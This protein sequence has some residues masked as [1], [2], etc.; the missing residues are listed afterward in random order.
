MKAA[1]WMLL[2]VLVSS[3]A[4]AV[5]SRTDFTHFTIFNG[6][7][8]TI[9]WTDYG[10][11]PNN[12]F[13]WGESCANVLN[14]AA[15]GIV[16]Q[17]ITQSPG[18]Q[19]QSQ[20]VIQHYPDSVNSTTP[21]SISYWF[22]S[23]SG[24][25][26]TDGVF[27]LHGGAGGSVSNGT[28]LLAVGTTGGSQVPRVWIGCNQTKNIVSSAGARIYTGTTGMVSSTGWHHVV[29]MVNNGYAADDVSIIVDNVTN[30]V[31]KTGTFLN[32]S[33]DTALPSNVSINALWVDNTAN[34]NPT[35]DI[36]VELIGRNFTQQEISELYNYGKGNEGEPDINFLNF[37]TDGGCTSPTS[38]CGGTSTLTPTFQV[39]TTSTAINNVTSCRVSNT[40]QLWSQMTGVTTTDANCTIASSTSTNVMWSC[41]MPSV[42]VLI[43]RN[44][45]ME[46]NKVKKANGE[47]VKVTT[48][49]KDFQKVEI[50]SGININDEIQKPK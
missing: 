15:T 40:S 48:G 20:N 18:F 19:Q 38:G 30:S 36:P 50:L 21:Y 17:A 11:T 45:L 9:N 10:A 44:Y 2:L 6:N 24:Q 27:Y 31:T 12:N 35:I 3:S 47:I 26:I 43:P 23:G 33:C 32:L 29:V 16:K 28:L 14:P 34:W 41:V 46:D 1:V 39:N 8:A 37:T 5:F 22:K 7:S 49:L 42:G 4:L 13:C 25:S